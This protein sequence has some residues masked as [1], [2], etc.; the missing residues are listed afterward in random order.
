MKTIKGSLIAAL[1]A[2]I[3]IF[4]SFLLGSFCAVLQKYRV[5][6]SILENY[7]SIKPSILLDDQGKEWARFA[8]DKREPVLLTDV[9]PYLIH[10]FIAAEDHS[11]FSHTGLSFRGILRSMVVN[12]Y[13]RKRVQGASTITQQLVRLLFLDTHRTFTRKIKEQI[14]ALVV[15]RQFSKEQILTT[16]LNNVYFGSGIYGVQAASNRFW[17]K[18]VQ[19]LSIAESATLAAIVKGAR[20]YSPLYNAEASLNRRNTVLHSM[21]KLGYISEQEYFQAKESDLGLINE[22]SNTIAPYL[23]ESLR[24]FLEELVGR[25]TLYTG[26]LKIQTTLNQHAQYHAQQEFFKQ[27]ATLKKTISL[28]VDG[29]LISMDVKTGEIKALVGG[30]NFLESQY[31]RA[32]QAKRQLGSIFKPIVYAAALQ[33]GQTFADTAIDEPIKIPQGKKVWQPHNYNK[34]FDGTMTLAHALSRSN[35]VVTVKTLLKTGVEPV[36]DL[37]LNCRL[38]NTMP[39]YPSL[40][41]GC[42]DVTLKQ[43]V[44]YF[45]VFANNGVY[46]EPHYV[47]WVKDENGKKI[48]SKKIDKQRV[49]DTKISS[50]VAQV[51]S[52]GIE[53]AKQRTPGNW[54]SCDALG[55]T[56]TTNDC[57]TCWFAGSTPNYTTALYIGCDDNRSLGKNVYAISTALPIWLGLHK[58]LPI[59]KKNFS[60][61]PSLKKVFIN[62]K[63]GERCSAPKGDQIVPVLIP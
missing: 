56:G 13:R 6:F 29:A 55:K 63:T 41:L 17:A 12:A 58:Q 8:L 31:N 53:R 54:I 14:L 49:M 3:L 28:A 39:A 16:Y 62:A 47:R 60:L 27:V 22:A 38:P 11:F 34:K 36:I 35:N 26:G 9:S 2:L 25:Q 32:E 30:Y 20:Y 50:Q 18:D 45:N 1:F 57:R 19:N 7:A 46:V 5:D 21:F 15:E 48:W 24:L 44:G 40:S 33:Q 61:D 4:F 37:A 59:E 23:K 42:V 52:L 43:A 10:A 51:L